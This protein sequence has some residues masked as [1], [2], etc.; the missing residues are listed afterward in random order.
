MEQ[1]YNDMTLDELLEEARKLPPPTPDQLHESA[2]SFAYGNLVLDG[3]KVT[4]EM[5]RSEAEKLRS[6]KDG[7]ST[8]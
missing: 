8:S 2:I 1:L 4:R 6:E 7:N 3:C 5:V